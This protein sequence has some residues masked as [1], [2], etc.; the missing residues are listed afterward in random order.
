MLLARLVVARP[1]ATRR[2][3]GKTATRK[4]VAVR[5]CY[6]KTA[7]IRGGCV[8]TR[9]Q[10]EGTTERNVEVRL[11]QERAAAIKE[12]PQGC[13]K[14]DCG[15]LPQWSVARHHFVTKSVPK[16]RSKDQEE[17]WELW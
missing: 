13:Q 2:C 15:K 8:A 10:Q 6:C 9:L 7:A 16:L 11:P 12:L 5:R 4:S 14:N 3:C 1:V 17:L